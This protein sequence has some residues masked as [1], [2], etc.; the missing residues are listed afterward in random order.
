MYPD[1]DNGILERIRGEDIARGARN[2]VPS[3]ARTHMLQRGGAMQGVAGPKD[4]F[5]TAR[6]NN[7][8]GW[9]VM[10]SWCPDV[11]TTSSVLRWITV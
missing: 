6:Q 8:I 9:A 5:A 2:N 4:H 3:I 10:L 1:H 11:A 7:G